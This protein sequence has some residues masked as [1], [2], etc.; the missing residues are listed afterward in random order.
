MVC[1]P[2]SDA[3]YRKAPPHGRKM[4]VRI[5]IYHIFLHKLIFNT[6]L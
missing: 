5:E 6:Y 1:A 2:Q 3:D 4:E